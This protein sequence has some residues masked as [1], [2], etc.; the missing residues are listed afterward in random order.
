MFEIKGLTKK[1][2]ENQIFSNISFSF[3]NK[4][5]YILE[6]EN[7]IGKTTLLSI[8]SGKDSNYSGSLIYNNKEIVKKN[9]NSFSDKFVT[10]IPQDSLVLDNETVINNVLLPYKTKDKEKATKILIDLGLEAIIDQPVSSLSSGERQRLA[11]ARAIYEIKEIV[12]LDEVTSN[13]DSKS[14]SIILYE[15]KRIAQE[16]LVIF[17]THGKFDKKFYSDACVLELTKQ[18]IEFHSSPSHVDN[19]VLNSSKQELN[20]WGFKDDVKSSF[21]EEKTSHIVFSSITAFL[22]ALLIIFF[23]FGFSFE[24]KRGS[25]DGELL[26]DK[27][28]DTLKTTLSETTPVF[29]GTKE[30]G[31]TGECLQVIN[32][33]VCSLINPNEYDFNV[34]GSAIS[35]FIQYPDSGKCL[36]YDINLVAGNIPK[37]DNEIIISDVCAE[38]LSLK[39]TLG[40]TKLW[41]TYLVTGIYKSIDLAN[42]SQ[43]YQNYASSSDFFNNLIDKNIFSMYSFMVDTSFI[44]SS[45]TEI[46]S[47]V[48]LANEENENQF[49]KNTDYLYTIGFSPIAVDKNG[50]QILEPFYNSSM[51][52]ILAYLVL[53]FLFSFFIVFIISFYFKNKDRYL[54]LRVMGIRRE[55]QTT[56]N[57]ISF[58]LDSILSYSIGILF[59]SATVAI[60]DSIYRKNLLGA[61]KTL[62]SF[63]FYPYIFGLAAILVF[64]LF[65]SFVLCFCLS[66]K[67]ISKEIYHIKEK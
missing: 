18:G 57:I 9:R 32:S 63:T 47:F 60:I 3:Q 43:R 48:F 20:N 24:S 37:E 56:A 62:F 11:F 53:L 8:L 10:Y 46:D 27:Y 41:N 16:S 12:L 28:N 34:S 30:D 26:Y 4:G 6:G 35:S 50:N 39:P 25:E 17:V 7:G 36:S 54:I 49:L 13:L 61:T 21:C 42:F 66:N 44:F 15:I 45:E 22:M 38:H 5:L 58:G 59:G 64:I 33:Q 67:D 31:Y 52:L 51:W 1:Y 14:A 29:F 23:S 65:F 40:A 2:G 55:K 19:N